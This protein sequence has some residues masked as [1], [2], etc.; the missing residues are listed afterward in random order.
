MLAFLYGFLGILVMNFTYGI[1]MAVSLEAG[2]EIS[3]ISALLYST[4]AA[5]FAVFLMACFFN[6]THAKKK[7]HNEIVAKKW[8]DTYIN[9]TKQH[10]A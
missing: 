3:F 6:Y 10:Q 1:I 8:V 2:H 7:K 9:D 5:L 4:V